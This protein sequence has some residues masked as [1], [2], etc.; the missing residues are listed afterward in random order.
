MAQRKAYD[1]PEHGTERWKIARAKRA[2]R[3]EEDEGEDDD[4]DALDIR[5]S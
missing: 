5:S 1:A 4:F 3:L 2:A